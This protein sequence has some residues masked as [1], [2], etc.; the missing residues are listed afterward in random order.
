MIITPSAP[1]RDFLC[2][3]FGVGFVLLGLLWIWSLQNAFQQQLGSVL[4][5]PFPIALFVAS[6]IA[7]IW[8]LLRYR[9]GGD[10]VAKTG[11]AL[12]KPTESVPSAPSVSSTAQKPRNADNYEETLK[13]L[14]RLGCVVSAILLAGFVVGNLAAV[15][16][17]VALA[18]VVIAFL[19]IMVLTP[20]G[21]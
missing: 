15:L 17:T 6:V 2:L 3:A 14:I 11:D 4:S 18:E 20:Q 21:L 5:N 16:V 10:G 7:G 1:R 13:W 12:A 9:G 19:L 8:L